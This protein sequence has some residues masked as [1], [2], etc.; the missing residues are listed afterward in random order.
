M[1]ALKTHVSPIAES[2]R[3]TRAGRAY[4]TPD[5]TWLEQTGWGVSTESAD[6]K[7]IYLHVIKAPAGHTL[8]L[9]PTADGCHLG[10]PATILPGGAAVDLKQ[11]GAIYQIT[12]PP[13]VRWSPLDTVIKVRRL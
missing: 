6:G 2:I 13:D 11:E 8:T 4:V 1:L 3:N 5:H 12:L 9:G 10:G 7:T